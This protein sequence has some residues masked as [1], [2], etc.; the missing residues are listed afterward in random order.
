MRIFCF[1][2][3]RNPNIRNSHPLPTFRNLKWDFVLGDRFFFEVFLFE[4]SFLEEPFLLLAYSLKEFA[5]RL[6]VG[7]LWHKSPFNGFL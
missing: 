2:K 4:F 5:C 1:T 7:V 3:L 6:V